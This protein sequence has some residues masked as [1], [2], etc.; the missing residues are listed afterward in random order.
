MSNVVLMSSVASDDLAVP[1]ARSPCTPS[2]R[3]LKLSARTSFYWID[4]CPQVSKKAD[5]TRLPLR[6]ERQALPPDLFSILTCCE[7]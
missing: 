1:T 3:V 2:S 7:P 4:G 5:L 6:R